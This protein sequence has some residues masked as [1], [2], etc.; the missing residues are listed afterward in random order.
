MKKV[1]IIV[2]TITMA[3]GLL[4]GCGG[5]KG[6]EENQ[7]KAYLALVVDEENAPVEGVSLQL[8]SDQACVMAKTDNTGIAQFDVDEGIY[9]LKVYAVPEGFAEDKSEYA[10]P[11]TYGLVQIVLK[12]VA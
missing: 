1:L 8:C 3:L 5:S 2:L 10:V 11:E 6:Q 4:V 9:T 12:P 7:V